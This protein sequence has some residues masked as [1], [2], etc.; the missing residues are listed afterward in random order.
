MK[1]KKIK[2]IGGPLS[3]RLVKAVG[4]HF[5]IGDK[6]IEMSEEGGYN[7][8]VAI[9][10]GHGKDNGGTGIHLEVLTFKSAME[11]EYQSLNNDLKRLISFCSATRVGCYTRLAESDY[12][13]RWL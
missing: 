1:A 10:L 8:E 7:N 6:D 9:Y 2:G 3:K 5:Q 13:F 4:E 12:Y 11:C